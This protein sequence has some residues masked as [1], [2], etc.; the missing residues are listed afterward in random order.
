M[1]SPPQSRPRFADD[2]STPDFGPNNATKNAFGE[3]HG[4]DLTRFTIAQLL[5]LRNDAT[6]A[7]PAA[8]LASIDLNRELVLQMLSIQQLQA[9]VLQDDGT[10]ANQKAQVANSLLSTLKQLADLQNSIFTSERMKRVENVLVDFI[11]GLPEDQRRAFIDA[12]E[13]ALRA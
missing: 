10:P 1:K 11:K 2:E 6:L 3:G 12:Y 13:A 8:D 9:D 4:V 5:Q 7:L